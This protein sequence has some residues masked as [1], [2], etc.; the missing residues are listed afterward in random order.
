MIQT[1]TPGTQQEPIQLLSF[2]V[3]CAGVSLS[4][5]SSKTTI[6]LAGAAAATKATA[7]IRRL[8][9]RAIIIPPHNPPDFRRFVNRIA[10]L[11]N[12]TSKNRALHRRKVIEVGSSDG[13]P[14]VPRA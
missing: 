10:P 3:F 2:V 8:R 4:K 14:G 12:L 7:S 13:L 1:N 5:L 11:N 6:A 9:Y